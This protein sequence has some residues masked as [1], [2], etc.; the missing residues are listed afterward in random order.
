M[1][2]EHDGQRAGNQQKIVKPILKKWSVQNRFEG[3]TI[4]RV[5]NAAE[6]KQ[7]IAQIGERSHNKARIR[8]PIPSAI[9]N[10]A[11]KVVNM[12]LS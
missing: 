4:E 1:H 9:A 10:F 8:S 2:P 11:S 5:K 6:N 3:P 7:R 12:T